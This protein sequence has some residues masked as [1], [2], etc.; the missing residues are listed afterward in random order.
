MYVYNEWM[1]RYL[2]KN[3]LKILD[4]AIRIKIRIFN[5]SSKFIIDNFFSYKL[6][7]ERVREEGK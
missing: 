7:V 3:K 2:L 4:Y 5:H 1:V 6:N